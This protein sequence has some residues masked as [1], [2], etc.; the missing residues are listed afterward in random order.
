M[1]ASFGRKK[2]WKTIQVERCEAKAMK[3]LQ[4]ELREAAQKEREVL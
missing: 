3:E 1:V 4:K 2:S